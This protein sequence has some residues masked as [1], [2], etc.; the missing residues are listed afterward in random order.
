MGTGNTM[1][2]TLRVH[3]RTMREAM[4]TTAMKGTAAWEIQGE[5]Q[6]YVARTRGTRGTSR[7]RIVR[8]NVLLNIQPRMPIRLRPTNPH[9]HHSTRFVQGLI[10]IVKHACLHPMLLAVLADYRKRV[11]VFLLGPL[12]KCLGPGCACSIHWTCDADIAKHDKSAPMTAEHGI[13]ALLVRREAGAAC[14]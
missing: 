6:I 9:R 5:G 1:T 3:M 7:N 13:Q 14:F 12:P 10:N 2:L 4:D 11:V 8:G